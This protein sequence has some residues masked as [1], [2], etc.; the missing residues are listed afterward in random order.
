MLALLAKTDYPFLDIMWTMFIFF[1]WLIWISLLVMVLADN[2][3]RPDHSG[4]AKAGWTLFVIFVPAHRRPGLHDRAAEGGPRGRVARQ[5]LSTPPA[6][7][8]AG[9]PGPARPFIH[10]GRCSECLGRG[11]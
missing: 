7:L 11:R 5:G 8:R 10:I 1:A 3:R 2:F 4:W 9:P 6:R